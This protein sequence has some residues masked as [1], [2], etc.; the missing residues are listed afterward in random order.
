M[1]V[2]VEDRLPAERSA[3]H[4]EPVTRLGEAEL[5]CELRGNEDH[6]AKKRS[7]GC[8]ELVERGDEAFGEDEEVV[9]RG[10]RD[11][12]DGDAVLVVPEAWRGDFAAEDFAE[13]GWVFAHGGLLREG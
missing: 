13:D 3:V 2:D 8:L 4:D 9:W 7:V 5:L 10:G 1:E 6:V 12:A 11:V